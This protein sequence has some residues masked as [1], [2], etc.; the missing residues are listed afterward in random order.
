MDRPP[1]DAYHS[2][3]ANA[4]GDPTNDP[5][6]AER[7]RREMSRPALFSAGREKRSGNEIQTVTVHEWP[8]GLGDGRSKAT[9]II[10]RQRREPRFQG[11]VAED[12]TVLGH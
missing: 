12:L 10:L 4:G 6:Y 1:T 2:S 11:D 3:H 8:R 7:R 9:Q 5:S